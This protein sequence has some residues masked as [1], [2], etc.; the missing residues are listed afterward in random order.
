MEPFDNLLHELFD[1][2]KKILLSSVPFRSEVRKLCEQNMCGKFGKTWTCPP[3]VGPLAELQSQLSQYPRVMVFSK[4]YQLTDSFDW[5][6]ME[7]G[8]KDFQSKV[9]QLKKKLKSRD[10]D[11]NAIVLGAGA[12]CIC[13]NCTY[14]QQLPCRNPEHA[15]V[16]VEACGID[17]M[18]MMKENGM[19][20]NNGANTVTYIGTLFY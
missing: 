15:I 10:P 20:Y 2:A 18:E 13:D 9:L 7:S 12:C 19:R 14:E 16:S 5:E 11:L 3:A 8:V 17:V 6:G 4:V 1:D